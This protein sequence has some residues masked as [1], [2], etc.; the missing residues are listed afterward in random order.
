MHAMPLVPPTQCTRLRNATL[1]CIV[2]TPHALHVPA[3]VACMLAVLSFDLVHQVCINALRFKHLGVMDSSHPD[4]ITLLKNVVRWVAHRHVR[5]NM[6]KRC[7]F[8]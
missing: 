2:Y 4:D 3:T 8:E 7:V 5:I 1:L 6:C